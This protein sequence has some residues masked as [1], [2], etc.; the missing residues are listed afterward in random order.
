MYVREDQA[1]ITVTVKDKTGKVVK[2]KSENDSWATYSGA[3]L[4]AAGSKTRPGGMGKQKALGGPATR[5]DATL[6]VQQ[7][8]AMIAI[9]S[10]LESRVGKGDCV[11]TL[12]Y[13]DG[14]GDVRAGEVFQGTGKLKEASLG[15]QNHDS[16][17]TSMYT[18]V[19]DM[20]EQAA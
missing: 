11:V 20:D 13:L 4:S 10:F 12:T 6:T 1:N 15:D 19:I 14:E 17:N 7:D 3:K 16:P 9:H 8:D 18:L 2:I 5:S